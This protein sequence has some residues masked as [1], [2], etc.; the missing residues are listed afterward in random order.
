MLQIKNTT[1]SMLKLLITKYEARSQEDID[2]EIR[3]WE[4]QRGYAR[5]MVNPNEIRRT[6]GVGVMEVMITDEQ[7]EAIRKEVLIAF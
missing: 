6:N 1:N 2:A 4:N 7:F 5:N 3:N